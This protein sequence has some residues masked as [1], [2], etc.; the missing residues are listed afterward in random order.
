MGNGTFLLTG[1]RDTLSSGGRDTLLPGKREILSSGVLII[2]PLVNV[3]RENA[4][5]EI[6]FRSGCMYVCMLSVGL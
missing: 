1:K 6:V 3:L 4:I 2:Y 5:W